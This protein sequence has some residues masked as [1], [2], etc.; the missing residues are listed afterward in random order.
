MMKIGLELADRSQML[1]SMALTLQNRL[2]ATDESVSDIVEQAVEE[3]YELTTEL[4]HLSRI[5]RASIKGGRPQRTIDFR[6]RG[7]T[8]FADEF[9][10]DDVATERLKRQVRDLIME[11]LPALEDARRLE[12]AEARLA[13]PE[14]VYLLLDDRSVDV[15]YP[16]IRG[17]ARLSYES[18]RDAAGSGSTGQK[19][20]G[21]VLSFL[22]L[23][24]YLGNV[25]ALSKENSLFVAL[26]NQFGKISSS[27]IIADIKK[28]VDQ[29][30]M[31]LITVAGRELRSAYTM[32]D[33]VFTLYR[34]ANAG[35]AH[36]TS[37][38]VR[39]RVNESDQLGADAVIDKFRAT[40]RFENLRLDL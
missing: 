29:T 39:V 5:S 27:K 4:F 28:V 1:R 18:T 23:L 15:R 33:V 31:Q 30:H 22:A 14:L 6:S 32:G 13:A 40:R 9:R 21:Y 20:A 12:R 2:R 37:R 10:R 38:A 36:G 19:S 16:V 7:R 35:S 26:E 11:E 8:V 17:G 3:G 34:S 24:R 25:G